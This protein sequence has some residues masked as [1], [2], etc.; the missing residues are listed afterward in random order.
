MSRI[1]LLTPYARPL[2]GG[3]SSFVNGLRE[4]LMRHGHDVSVVCGEGAGD[5][6][7]RSNVGTGLHFVGVAAG[8][9]RRIAPD[10]I[11]CHAHWHTL[12]AALRY[13][14]FNSRARVVFSFHTT[15]RTPW[16]VFLVR[17]LKGADILTF[18]SAYQLAS[19][20]NRLQLG[21]DLRIL[22]PATD[23]NFVRAE[24]ID[25]WQ[26][27]YGVKGCFP[28][29]VFV[30]PLEYPGKVAGVLELI[31]SM[32]SVRSRFA[33]ARLIVVGDGKYRPRV[34]AAAKVLGESVLLI[35]SQTDPY[36][37]FAS[38]DIYSHI[39]YE[40]SFGIAILEA[41]AL[42]RCVLASGEGG[43][44]EIIDGSNGL[45]VSRGAPE[46]SSALIRLAEDPATRIRLGESARDTVARRHT[47][48]SRYPLLSSIYGLE[49]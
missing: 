48:E 46:I 20:R 10:I 24:A 31:N 23:I 43:I 44:A 45:L 16:Q 49:A 1:A 21:G 39:S 5:V 27:Q 36:P 6:P 12:A 15:I 40:E 7:E 4:I 32:R 25:D 22:R 9:L 8:E 38:A 2:V 3:I 17:W 13:R 41:M 14:R 29:F 11:H 19:L 37:A 35:G 26:S 42:G 18:V 34:A 30:G 33:T 47:W 28:L